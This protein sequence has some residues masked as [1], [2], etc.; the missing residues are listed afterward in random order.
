MIGN[1]H[2]KCYR[3]KLLWDFHVQT[4]KQVISYQPDIVIIKKKLKVS[5]NRRHSSPK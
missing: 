5:N 1:N 3:A 2:G 4:D